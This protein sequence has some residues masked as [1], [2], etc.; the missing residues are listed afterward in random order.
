MPADEALRNTE[1]LV[2]LRPDVLGDV[3]HAVG[4]LLQRMHHVARAAR[5]ELGAPG[6]RLQATLDELEQLLGLF[7]DYVSPVALELRPTAAARVAES[8]AAQLRGHGAEVTID[9]AAAPPVLADPRTLSRSFTLLGQAAA[10]AWDRL[11]V[12]IATAAD[13][14]GERV[15]LTVRAALP[16]APLS[17][18]GALATAVARR[19]IELQ[20]GELIE[21]PNPACACAVVLPVAG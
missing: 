13:A 11:P 4:N 14:S 17:A 16:S 7:F 18:P 12:V 20:G 3:E 10:S 21:R 6:E 1:Q 9:T 2:A 15:E 8:L 19:L 5:D